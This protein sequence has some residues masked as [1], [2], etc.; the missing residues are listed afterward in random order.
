M[1][2]KIIAA[3]VLVL[4]VVVF[5]MALLQKPSDYILLK[6]TWKL[7][8][9]VTSDT[10]FIPDTSGVVQLNPDFSFTTTATFMP[11]TQTGLWRLTD[12]I[13]Y[14]TY[15]Y[16]VPVDSIIY[17]NNNGN[18]E[19]QLLNNKS[20]VSSVSN[21][22]LANTKKVQ[23]L[24]IKTLTENNLTITLNNNIYT[25]TSAAGKQVATDINVLDIK[26]TSVL[27]GIL[28]MLVLIFIAWLFSSNRKAIS[29]KVVGIGLAIQLILAF[30]ILKVPAIAW[31][32]ET[33]GKMFVVILNF[34]GEGSKFL[35]GDLLNTKSF[36]FI[37]AFQVLPTIIFFS[38]LTS[39]LFYVGII[40]KVVY[41][42]AWL[43]T[44]ALKISGA[45]SLSVAG[46]I[47]LGQTEAPL[48]IK[49]YLEKMNR[50]EIMMVM[51]G[52]MATLAGGVLA[53][54][55]AFLGGDDPVQRIL[56][57]KHLIAASVMAA[58][59]VI[60]LGKIIVPQTEPVITDIEIT[61]DKI[62][63]N[64]LDAISNG[65]TEG[66]KLAAN[67]A[68]MLLS[69]IAFIA[70]FNFI[71][72]KL[73]AYTGLNE[74]IH[75]LDPQYSGLDLKFILGYIFAPI[76]WLMGVTSE[77]ITL[78]GRLLGEKLIMTEFIAY[79][80]LTDLKSAGDA[81]FGSFAEKKSIIMA[82]YALAG[83]ANFASIGIQ[84]G[85]ISALAPGKR[86]QLSELGFRALLAGSLASMMSATMVGM[87][88]S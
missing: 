23:K 52:G 3:I 71:L 60:V 82:T 55:I 78:V 30:G 2:R 83:F 43:L 59:G 26:L 63:S 21:N 8:N 64:V 5:I 62:G 28:G 38:A 29:W 40:Q 76:V 27:R 77:D 65:T 46:N 50:S 84:I 20:E 74:V 35:L 51:S 18:P 79:I 86:T 4:L 61:K 67:V 32:F 39:L 48:M 57:A 24:Y 37:F 69:F 88:I 25:F 19:L 44:K 68:A 45:E 58:P 16:Q 17:S 9:V 33:V 34:T 73:G 85:G 6:N 10:T 47:F 14:L 1:K 53:S 7:T 15:N 80:S 70:M 31:V 54:Y 66:L 36:G 13:I 72:R 49:A 42:L 11:E 12:S 81:A 56:F 75:Q 41:V 22:K 87:L